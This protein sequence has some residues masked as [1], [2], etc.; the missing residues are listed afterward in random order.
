MLI[1]KNIY[2][3]RSKW[4]KT[5]IVYVFVKCIS[6]DDKTCV[7]KF[8]DDQKLYFYPKEIKKLN[9]IKRD[10][11]YVLKVE[12]GSTTTFNIEFIKHIG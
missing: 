11:C 9:K 2:D 8:Y 10:E 7:F 12:T 3:Y 5:S 6:V 4:H 1:C